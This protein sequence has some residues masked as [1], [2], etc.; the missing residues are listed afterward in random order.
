MPKPLFP[1]FV[2]VAFASS[3]G[4]QLV[5]DEQPPFLPVD[6]RP[7]LYSITAVVALEDADRYVELL[8]R[9]YDPFM[10]GCGSPLVQR[11]RTVERGYPTAEVQST[12]RLATL[13]ASAPEASSGKD[14]A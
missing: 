14:H 10:A 13:G 1:A 4:C 9:L 2:I 8:E 6:D 11:L 12:W 5:F 7:A 3:A